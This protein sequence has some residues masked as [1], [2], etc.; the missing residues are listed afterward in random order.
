M[1]KEVKFTVR[2]L[3]VIKQF[4]REVEKI[5]SHVE[6]HLLHIVSKARQEPCPVCGQ[7]AR[8]AS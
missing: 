7:V 5:A 1:D 8:V 3:A 2:D 4:A 6:L